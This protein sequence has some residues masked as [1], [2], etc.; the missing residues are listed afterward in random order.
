MCDGITPAEQDVARTL[1]MGDE[2]VEVR[3]KDDRGLVGRTLMVPNSLWGKG[4]GW[5]PH[6]STR[7]EVVGKCVREY[8]FRDGRKPAP[9]YV[10]QAHDDSE[11]YPIAA[12]YLASLFADERVGAQEDE[13]EDETPALWVQCEACRKWRSLSADSASELDSNARWECSMHPDAALA[14]CDAPEEQWDEATEPKGCSCTCL[15]KAPLATRASS[16]GATVGCKSKDVRTA[17][18]FTSDSSPRRWRAPSLRSLH[19]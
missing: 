8:T 14:Q 5:S 6:G 10:I 15:A 12:S 7:C 3:G 1:A 16:G 4:A 9:A 18:W 17:D 11:C 2:E 19:A 13:D